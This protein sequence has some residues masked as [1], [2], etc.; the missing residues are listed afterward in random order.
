MKTWQNEFFENNGIYYNPK[1]RIISYEQFV[2]IKNIDPE[3]KYDNQT[4][5]LRA[6]A[7]LTKEN[8][9]L[10]TLKDIRNFLGIKR[11]PDTELDGHAISFTT[12][13]R[14]NRFE[15]SCYILNVA[16]QDVNDIISDQE[17]KEIYQWYTNLE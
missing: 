16:M 12:R 3:M 9:D 7:Y 1:G 5:F 4:L 14:E 11:L 6:T 8:K 2:N 13:R 10:P 15:R 17:L